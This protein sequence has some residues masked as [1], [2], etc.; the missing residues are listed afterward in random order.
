MRLQLPVLGRKA[1]SSS[2]A[3]AVWAAFDGPSCS[4]DGAAQAP[5]YIPAAQS[6]LQVFDTVL[7][8]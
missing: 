1:G 4:G 2:Q 6:T 5:D 8:H 3:T 7:Q